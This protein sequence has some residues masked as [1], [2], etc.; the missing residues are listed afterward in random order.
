[1]AEHAVSEGTKAPDF[2]AAAVA[3]GDDG[4]S[5]VGLADFLGRKNVVLYF[6]P[7]DNTPGC[8]TEAT[9]FRDALADFAAADT[10]VLGVSKDSVRSHCSFRD[11]HALSFPLL[12]D[13]DGAIVAAYDVWREKKMYGKAMMGV[14]RSTFLIDKQGVVRKAWRKVK[15]KGHAP[16]VLAA[17]RIV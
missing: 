13:P 14:E 16:E 8:T 1:M 6:Y 15:V 7:R 5:E 3:T 12:S 10:V 2:R 9:D 17:A 11:K 4:G